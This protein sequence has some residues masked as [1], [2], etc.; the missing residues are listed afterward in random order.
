MQGRRVLRGFTLIELLATVSVVA[1]LGLVAVPS[2][3]S[4][5]LNSER[6][7]TVN[8]FFHALFYARSESIKRGKIVSLCRSMDGEQCATRSAGWTQ[9][10]IVFV[11]EDRDDPA[12]R[13]P[14]EPVLGVY[15]GWRGGEIISNR[16][17]YSFRPQAQA[18]VNGTIL[19]CDP[20]GP[21]E[22][23]AIIISHT[24]RPRVSHRDSAGRALNCPQAS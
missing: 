18:V 22:S 16:L 24:G 6:T 13:D 4:L 11:N 2:F 7:V 21:A 5:R 3:Q 20:R 8:A 1:I 15:E 23:R 9:G 10:W 19:F 14:Q 17:T 12:E